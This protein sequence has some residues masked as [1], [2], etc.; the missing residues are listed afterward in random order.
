MII[1]NNF[2]SH[3]PQSLNSNTVNN[4]HSNSYLSEFC[5]YSGHPVN[6]IYGNSVNVFEHNCS[7]HPVTLIY[8]NSVDKLKHELFWPTCLLIIWQL[9]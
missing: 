2:I 7:G 1:K 8:G 4:E 3:L 6:L 9:C 5:L